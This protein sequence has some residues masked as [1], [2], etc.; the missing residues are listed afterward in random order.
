M[1]TM[2]LVSKN[3]EIPPLGDLR[4][5]HRH[6]GEFILGFTVEPVYRKDFRF[7]VNNRET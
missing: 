2:I 1:K 3:S 6:A 5:L 4:E 7:Q